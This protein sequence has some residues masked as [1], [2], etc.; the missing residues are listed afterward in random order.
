LDAAAFF[1]EMLGDKGDD[2]DALPAADPMSVMPASCFL[3]LLP[4]V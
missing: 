1:M 3:L 2:G 4:K